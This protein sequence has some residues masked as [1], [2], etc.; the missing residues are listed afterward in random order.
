MAAPGNFW[1]NIRGTFSSFF[2]FG[3]NNAGIRGESS[4]ELA[5]RN[6]SDS[7]LA[8]LQVA[9]P[10]A[11]NHAATKQYVDAIDRPRIVSRQA[12]CSVA[13]PNNTAS[14]GYVVVTTAGSG[15]SIGDLLYDDGSSSGQM[16][17]LPAVEGQTIAVTDALAGG[18]ISLDADSFYIWDADGSAWLKIGDIGSVTNAVKTIRFAINNSASQDSTNQVPAGAYVHKCVVHVVT[19]YSGG[20]DI[21]IGDTTTADKFLGTNQVNAQVAGMYVVEQSTNQ[22]SASVVR[23]TITGAPAA[24]AG[25]VEV[26]YSLPLA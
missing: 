3:K 18:T 6:A 10:T 16:T 22:A 26:F 7:G 12:D 1:A 4:S 23:K 21:S 25:F 20:A 24:G 11:D 17:I 19:P 15:A 13:I 14:A 5:A 9:T 8:Q 2:S